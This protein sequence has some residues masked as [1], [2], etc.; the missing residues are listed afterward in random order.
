MK[1]TQMIEE[2]LKTYE[3]LGGDGRRAVL[4]KNGSEVHDPRPDVIDMEAER[5]P[6]LQEMVKR[7]VQ[8][9]RDLVDTGIETLEDA[10][11]FDIPEDPYDPD[12][13]M[14]SGFEVPEEPIIDP[15]PDSSEPAVSDD[16]IPEPAADNNEPPTPAAEPVSGSDGGS[17][18]PASQA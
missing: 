16:P 17:T 11:D 1:Y 4:D 15:V 6:S 3:E 13:P 7:L 8:T 14:E 5:P 12:I 2:R 18:D 9:E 10:N